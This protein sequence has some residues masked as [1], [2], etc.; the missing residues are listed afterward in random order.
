VG[1]GD[2]L[3]ALHPGVKA[4]G[5]CTRCGTF[6]CAGCLSQHGDDWLCSGCQDRL[7]A[8]PW[9]EREQLGLWRAW[10][11]TSVLMISSPGQT[12]A[13]APP[14][15]P[16]GSSMLFIGLSTLVGFGP[17]FAIYLFGLGP[18]M[19]LMN[20]KARASD[21]NPILVVTGMALY[22]VVLLVLQVVG[23]LFFAALEHLSLMLVG[24][25]PRGFGVSVRASALAMGPY[26]VGLFPLCSFYVFPLWSLVL[27]IFAHKALH[28]TTGGRATAAVLLPL[29]VL[30]GAFGMLYAAIIALAASLRP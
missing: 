8:L 9:D 12:L 5:A 2:A 13:H 27:R 29:V 25:Q 23:T 1:A 24:A 19:V 14:D 3:C 21:L 6:G 28:Q 10:W 26:L 17:T 15:A 7:T 20:I 4:I 30:C 11:R 16:L 18:L 22:M